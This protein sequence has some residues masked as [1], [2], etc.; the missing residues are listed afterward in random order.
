MAGAAGIQVPLVIIATITGDATGGDDYA[1][2]RPLE[3]VDCTV[4]ATATS[5]GGTVAVSRA[6][7]AITGAI[8]CAVSGAV[9]RMTTYATAGAAFNTGELMRFTTNGAADRGMVLVTCLPPPADIQ[10]LV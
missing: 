4:I 10:A 2:S 3:V 1:V 9:T 5:G 6:A 7:T 8:V